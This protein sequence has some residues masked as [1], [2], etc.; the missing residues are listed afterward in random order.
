[1]D[2][3]RIKEEASEILSKY[4]RIKTVNPPGNE[5]DAA[6]FL[7]G[8]L[9]K[10]GL[11]C[12]IYTSVPKRANVISRLKG[13]DSDGLILLSHMDVVPAVE[14]KWDFDPFGG[15]R[16]DGVIQGRGTLDDKG[17]GVM[18]LMAFLLIV[19]EGI[20]L[21]K[22]LVFLATGDEETGGEYGAGYMVE[23]HRD[24]LDGAFLLNEGGTRL[25]GL[26]PDG[27]PL[28]MVG[29]GEK[30]PLWLELKRAGTS[31]HASI[32]V[33]DN[34]VVALS[35]AISRLARKKR[36]IRF[37]KEMV[38]F[39]SGL[40]SGMGGPYGLFLKGV[41]IPLF[42][43]LVGRVVK[44]DTSMGAML[45]DTVSVTTMKA[46]IKENVIPDEARAIID[47]RLLPGT[48]KEEFIDWVKEGL[49]DDRVEIRELIESPPSLS[50]TDTDFFSAIDEV[51]SELSP[52]SITIPMVYSA[53]TDSRYF[54]DIGITSYGLIPAG[55]TSHDLRGIHGVNEQI[56][57]E[58][59]LSGIQFIY[60]LILKLC[61]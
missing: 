49:G 2:W 36:P 26:L 21:E 61:M 52:D 8:I 14:D 39:F 18:S 24:K 15:K 10:E 31:G 1:M 28:F 9:R 30:G 6:D 32:P 46:G 17:M 58:S 44:R 55:V 20:K 56:S 7:S 43:P 45:T 59:L 29:V 33:K 11:P 54:R 35:M 13:D 22:D 34:A 12:D 38:S 50:P 53:F 51:S 47:C 42:R 25:E 23:N 4:V 3:E 19:R 60:N 16:V 27:R 40:G 37:I 48:E 5:E 57:E 41:R